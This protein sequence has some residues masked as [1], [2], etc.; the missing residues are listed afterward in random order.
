MPIVTRSNS[1]THGDQFN[2][3]ELL[4]SQAVPQTGTLQ[5]AIEP[6]SEEKQQGPLLGQKRQII[7]DQKQTEIPDTK[8]KREL[9]A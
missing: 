9:K 5:K 7:E 4:G 6:K 1:K 2:W 3:R 8:R